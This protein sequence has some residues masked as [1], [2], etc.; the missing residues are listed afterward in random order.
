MSEVVVR[1]MN[2][3]DLFA[4][5]DDREKSALSTVFRV[6]QTEGGELLCREGEAARSFFIVARGAVEV[7]KDLPGDRRERLAN[8]GPNN[9]LGQV[10]LIDGEARSATL[11][12]TPGTVVLECSRDA[13]ERLFRAGS[14]FAMK[15]L[16]MIVVQ[17]CHRLR[18]ADKQLYELYTNPARTLLKLHD[19]ALS[20]SRTIEDQDHYRR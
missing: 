20:I 11:V 5:L 7:Y 12:V 1:L 8:V 19:A 15:V 10:A 18:E 16:D 4:G 3:W 13:F 17:L 14:P 9:L 2:E 6:R